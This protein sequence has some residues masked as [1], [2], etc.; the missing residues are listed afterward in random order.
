MQQKISS[1]RGSRSFFKVITS[2]EVY[3]PI[4]KKTTPFVYRDKICEKGLNHS[5]LF[6]GCRNF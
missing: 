4:N 2:E 1:S 5:I 6:Q 3:A